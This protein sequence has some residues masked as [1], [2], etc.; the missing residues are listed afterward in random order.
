MQKFTD[1]T[2]PMILNNGV[3]IPCVGFGTFQTP[4]EQTRDVV[5][6]ALDAGYR[7]IDTAAVYQNETGVGQAVAQ[8]NLDRKDVFVTSKLWN[9]NRGYDTTIAAFDATLNRLGFDY[10]DLYLIHWPANRK[11]LGNKAQEINAE[12]WRAFEDLYETGKVRA[13]G[14]SNFMPNHIEELLET[15][16]IKPMV[17]QIEIH[18]GWAQAEAVQYNQKRGILVEAWSPLGQAASLDDEY[19]VAIADKYGHTPAQVCMRWELQ[20]GILPLPKSVHKDRIISNMDAFG[21]ELTDAEMAIIG[22]RRGLG[23]SCLI[24]DRVDF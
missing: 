18:P 23:G 14:L 19:I 8:S 22:S 6:Q 20:Q 3:E 11:Q 7:H 24:P 2:S 4:P 13:I 21:F 15:A 17:N 1:V 10:L 12:T 16:R 9:T 5:L